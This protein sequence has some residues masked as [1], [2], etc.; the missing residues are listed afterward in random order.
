L[1]FSALGPC[2][3]AGRFFGFTQIVFRLPL[4]HKSTKIH[5]EEF[6]QIV[7]LK[8]LS[9]L[10]RFYFASFFESP[11][12]LERIGVRSYRFNLPKDN[13]PPSEGLGEAVLLLRNLGR[14]FCSNLVLTLLQTIQHS[15]RFYLYSCIIRS[16]IF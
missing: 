6:L 3:P 7:F 8:E 5:K 2:L 15:F 16:R 10:Q 14:L 13:S 9:D 4:R 12:P 1:I 11:S